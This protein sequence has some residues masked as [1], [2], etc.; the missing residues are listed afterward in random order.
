MSAAY[1]LG[2]T[3]DIRAEKGLLNRFRRESSGPVK[4]KILEALGKCGGDLSLA[5]LGEPSLS[6]GSPFVMK[7]QALGLYRAVLGKKH[8]PAGLRT[9]VTILLR[10]G[11]GDVRLYA[12]HVLSRIRDTDLTEYFAQLKA[13]A[14]SEQREDVK[15]N[16]VT[17]IGKCRLPEAAAYL[18]ALLKQEPGAGIT[19]NG[20]RALSNFSNIDSGASL[21]QLCLHQSYQISVAASETLL[22]KPRKEDAPLYFE[23]AKQT[24]HWRT[25]ANLYRISLRLSAAGQEISSRIRDQYGKMDN[26]YGKAALLSALGEDPG[27]YPFV[28]EQLFSTSRKIISTTGMIT[29]SQMMKKEGFDPDRTEPL[30]KGTHSLRKVFA[31]IFIRGVESGDS[32]LMLISSGALRDPKNKFKSVISHP[33]FIQKAMDTYTGPGRENLMKDL[34][35]TLVFFTGRKMNKVQPGQ[36][37]K[38]LDWEK[39]LEIPEDRKVAVETEEGEIV[40]RLFVNHSPGSVA[41]FLDLIRS[42]YLGAS[43]FH[44][45]VPNFVIQD[46]CPRGDGWGGPDTVIRSE[47]SDLYYE[48]GSL[49]MASGGK[50]TEGSQWFITH[51][52]TPHLDG[53]Y[54]IFGKVVKGMEVVHRIKVGTAVRGY[55][56][57]K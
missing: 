48:E 46:G 31:D 47:F 43:V 10:K 29:I 17:A 34:G 44:R 15:M 23:T 36:V 42:G 6:D 5:V 53:R 11:D 2:Q 7:G 49:G 30:G 54:T 38:K 1:A 40:V 52:T 4:E 33:G 14:E 9:V 39:I 50:D 13:L 12:S 21:L 28:E 41:N 57:M 35:Q 56:I 27:S 51:S 3:G 45:V 19:V 20:I 26:P 8:T 16:L 32:S 25:A 24:P 55:R 18:K 22:K 37:K